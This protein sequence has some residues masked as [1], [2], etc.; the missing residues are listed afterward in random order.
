[1]GFDDSEIELLLDNEYF[2][3]LTDEAIIEKY[4]EIAQND[5]LI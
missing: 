5:P 1:M 2:P 4:L 3:G